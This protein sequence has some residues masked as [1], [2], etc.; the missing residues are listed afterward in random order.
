VGYDPGTEPR[1][2]VARYPS[3]EDE[4]DLLGAAEVEVLA[5]HLFEE[6]AAVHRPVEHLSG[7]ELR[8]QDRDVVA[9][10]G[11]AVR[12]GEGMRQ[13]PQPFAQ[14]R[15]DL[16]GRKALADRLQPLG[17]GASEDAVVEGFEG[18]ALLPELALGVFVAVQAQLGIE[19]KVAAEFEEERSE[20]PVD[21]V[22]VVVVH[23]RAAPHDPRIG[24][25]RA[26]APASL[27]AEHGRV[28]LRLADEHDPL[29]MRKVP[30][31]LGHDRILALPLAKL[32]EWDPMPGRKILQLRHKAPG[33]RAHQRCRRHRLPAM[34]AKKPDNPLFVLQARHKHVEV[35]PVDPLDR[36]PHMAADDLGHALCYH[37]PGSDR[38]GFAS[39]R[40]LDRQSVP[41]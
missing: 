31:M 12:S 30:Q 10:A 36:Q 7:R 13:E 15:V 9:V 23:H 5:D 29:L 14:Q 32:H 28:L 3:I 41:Y 24:P 27:G 22:D 4:L 35:H 17:I 11:L 33:H 2:G 38:A 1:L 6:Q 40:R 39:R 20:I 26:R 16:A 37:P 21:G 34:I 19:R 25:A 18:D 8:L